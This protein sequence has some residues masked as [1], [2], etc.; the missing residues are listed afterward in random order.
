MKDYISRAEI[1]ALFNCWHDV[2]NRKMEE[3]IG[4][5]TTRYGYKI[6]RTQLEDCMNAVEN[7]PAADVRPAEYGTWIYYVD[8]T[9]GMTR[10]KCSNCKTSYGCMD[11]PF[12][13]NCGADMGT[14][15]RYR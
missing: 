10:C 15:T 7:F 8:E 5:P 13:P 1:T 6:C 9:T 14:S 4:F 2:L 3:T 11:T 12:C